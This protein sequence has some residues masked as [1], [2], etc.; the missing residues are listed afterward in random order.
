MIGEIMK[1]E[2]VQAR[3]GDSATEFIQ[4]V[5][6]E[7]LD[8]LETVIEIINQRYAGPE[9]DRDREVAIAAAT[10]CGLGRETLTSLATAWREAKT[11][12][13]E[14]MAAL[15]GG[16]AWASTHDHRPDIEIVRESGLA[17]ETVR[18]ALGRYT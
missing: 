1:T 4:Q 11:R 17:R 5:G 12:E 18:R 13:R 2:D 7:G 14:A 8:D 10:A 9:P 15:I 6:Q 3:L 16:V